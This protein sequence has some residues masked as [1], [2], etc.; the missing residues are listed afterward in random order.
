MLGIVYSLLF[1][2][3]QKLSKRKNVLYVYVQKPIGLQMFLKSS[4]IKHANLKQTK[5]HKC[6]TH[7]PQDYTAPLPNAVVVYWLSNEH[8]AWASAQLVVMPPNEVG[9]ISFKKQI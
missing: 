5:Q 4:K 8:L 3:S 7:H 6:E 1:S 9:G 2:F